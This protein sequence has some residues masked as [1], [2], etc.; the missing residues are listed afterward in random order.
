M[1]Y[2][3]GLLDSA[4]AKHD[5]DKV[6][7]EGLAQFHADF[8]TGFEQTT[9]WD[10]HRKINR[11]HLNEPD[12]VRDDV[13]LVDLVEHA[14]DCATAGMARSGKVYINDLPP[15]VLQKAFRNTIE[16]LAFAIKVEDP[17]GG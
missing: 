8:A 17:A 16:K 14:V 5:R 13:D 12:G 15:E 2:L 11:H 9:W 1:R 6:T 4:A 7:P 3:C 10:N